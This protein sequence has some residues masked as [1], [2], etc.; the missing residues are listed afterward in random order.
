MFDVNNLLRHESRWGILRIW[1]K[2][3]IRNTLRLK[4]SESSCEFCV[5]FWANP[6]RTFYLLYDKA[7]LSDHS[8][9]KLLDVCLSTNFTVT[10]LNH[11]LRQKFLLPENDHICPDNFKMCYNVNYTHSSFKQ[12][13]R[14]LYS[15][16]FCF[17]LSLFCVKAEQFIEVFCWLLVVNGPLY[18]LGKRNSLAILLRVVF[19]HIFSH[20]FLKAKSFIF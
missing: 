6:K 5:N 8:W 1:L 10:D 12:N 13:F 17:L 15:R 7:Y 11:K 14:D 4:W 9:L 20:Q 2:S 18:F 16:V 3:E 19:R